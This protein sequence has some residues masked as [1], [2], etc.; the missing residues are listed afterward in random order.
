MNRARAAW[1]A[2]ALS[3]VVLLGGSQRAAINVA[4]D[5][6]GRI[7]RSQSAKDAFKKEHPCPAN[8]AISGSCP[9]FIIDH[10]EP[11]KR[12]GSDIP[13]NMQWQTIPEAK[14]KDKVE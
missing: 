8:G 11:L 2:F 6:H 14:A 4:R 9:G 3:A 10:I 7:E 12:G 13:S 1:G 5:S